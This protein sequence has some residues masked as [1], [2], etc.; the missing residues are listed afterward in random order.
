[1]ILTFLLIFF[2][3]DSINAQ[4]LHGIGNTEFSWILPHSDPAN[5]D[6]FFAASPHP[7]AVYKY[8]KD[9]YAWLTVHTELLGSADLLWHDYLVGFNA[10]SE[11]LYASTSSG[12]IYQ[13]SLKEPS[14]WSLTVTLSQRIRSSVFFVDNNHL[15]SVHILEGMNGIIRYIHD[16]KTELL[17]L[18][19][20]VTKIMALSTKTGKFVFYNDFRGICRISFD[21]PVSLCSFIPVEITGNVDNFIPYWRDP[22][23]FYIIVSTDTGGIVYADNDLKYIADGKLLGEDTNTAFTSML[24]GPATRVA[25]RLAYQDHLFLS[26]R[27]GSLFYK[28]LSDFASAYNSY[29]SNPVCDAPG[30]KMLITS[31]Q[32]TSLPGSSYTLLL[33]TSSSKI[34]SILLDIINPPN[35]PSS[36]VVLE[37]TSWNPQG[38][39]LKTFTVLG[40]NEKTSVIV[41]NSYG[42]MLTLSDLSVRI[43]TP[44]PFTN[45]PPDKYVQG[46][47]GG[48]PKGVFDYSYWAKSVELLAIYYQIADLPV[49]ECEIINQFRNPTPIGDCCTAWHIG[50]YGGY[51]A[52]NYNQAL[53]SNVHL[54]STR[55]VGIPSWETLKAKLN[56]NSVVMAERDSGTDLVALFGYRESVWENTNY[57]QQIWLSLSIN[58]Y[59]PSLVPYESLIKGSFF[60]PLTACIY[61]RPPN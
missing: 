11:Y 52:Y 55:R 5:G 28:E 6:E 19:S 40:S 27:N 35:F 4:A 25:E 57:E 20:L 7:A 53:L 15:Y 33:F 2:V 46:G 21:D 48:F 31:V 49:R 38:Y 13:A 41:S 36:K 12:K 24:I 61:L 14:V 50:C 17:K 1:M 43:P 42:Q 8:T 30:C 47:A 3:F 26:S 18:A 56:T 23:H 58:A 51:N 44:S 16:Q 34:L 29:P 9:L 45:A 10:I 59:S 54:A 39:Q 37:A 60:R 32:D 22:D